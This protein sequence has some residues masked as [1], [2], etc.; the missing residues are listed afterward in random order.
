MEELKG[1]S[2]ENT[3]ASLDAFLA[4]NSGLYTELSNHQAL[5]VSGDHNVMQ[6]LYF[7]I[8]GP[9]LITVK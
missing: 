2:I 4:A 9:T 1:P 3:T 6:Y 8:S 7:K 5:E